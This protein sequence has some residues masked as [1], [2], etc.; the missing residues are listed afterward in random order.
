MTLSVITLLL[1]GM[2]I[3]NALRLLRRKSRSD[4]PRALAAA[5]FHHLAAAVRQLLLVRFQAGVHLRRLA[6][7][8]GAEF[9]G[10]RTAGHL[11]LGG[12]AR[13]RLSQRAR[14]ERQNQRGR[15]AD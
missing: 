10:I 7:M 3:G 5:R 11:L 15:G 9:S 6:D 4:F 14:S 2:I 1:F 8:F 13:L 12:G